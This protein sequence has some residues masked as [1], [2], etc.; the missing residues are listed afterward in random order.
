MRK[1]KKGRFYNP[2]I[3]KNQLW[4]IDTHYFPTKVLANDGNTKEKL[5]LSSYD[6]SRTLSRRLA[7]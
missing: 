3:I 5:F 1:K 2:S 6:I 4:K 7:F